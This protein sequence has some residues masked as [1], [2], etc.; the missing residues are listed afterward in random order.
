MTLVSPAALRFPECPACP[1]LATYAWLAARYFADFV[2]LLHALDRQEADPWDVA[3]RIRLES[4]HTRGL[5]MAAAAPDQD[6]DTFHRLY[7]AR[8]P[9]VRR[10]E[11]RPGLMV[12]EATGCAFYD[13]LIDIGVSGDRLRRLSEL[14]CIAD[15]QTVTGFNSQVR[16]VQPTNL[17]HGDRTCRW[18]HVESGDVAITAGQADQR[19]PGPIPPVSPKLPHPQCDDCF[20]LFKRLR[21]R[22]FLD[23]VLAAERWEALR[24]CS[25]A[26]I[27]AVVRGD[28]FRDEGALL[29]RRA[30]GNSLSDLAHAFWL[31]LPYVRL[32]EQRQKRW[33]F[34]ATRYPF[35]ET[36]LEM[37]LAP[38]RLREF[39][40]LFG[41]MEVGI[42]RGFNPAIRVVRTKS[43]FTGDDT[44]EWAVEA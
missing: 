6:L 10:V 14:T 41:L 8:F 23:F 26:E 25:V 27:A 9:N 28:N 20:P 29:A 2:D 38:A 36:F 37:K 44:M 19:G 5:L 33:M 31:R 42:G 1:A 3:R 32:I 12:V 16:V 15:Q 35:L 11:R 21:A 39:D 40:E 4:A 7:W 18:V 24:G 13:G 30:S 22:H 34:R 17:M 43:L